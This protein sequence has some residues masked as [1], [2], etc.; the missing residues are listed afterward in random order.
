M[1]SVNERGELIFEPL[2]III[3]SYWIKITKVP[4]LN[5]ILFQFTHHTISVL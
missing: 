5:L 1:C 2:N 3:I 4:Y